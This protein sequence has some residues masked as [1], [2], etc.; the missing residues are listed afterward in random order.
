MS[1][2]LI[3]EDMCPTW[4]PQREPFHRKNVRYMLSRWR[5]QDYENYD[6]VKNPENPD[7]AENHENLD[8]V[9]NPGKILTSFSPQILIT[10]L[11]LLFF[12]WRPFINNHA[13]RFV[14]KKNSKRNPLK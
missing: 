10:C 11:G 14:K 3:C 9:E 12:Q 8:P 5:N 1:N 7:P 2:V 6:P 13:L 4:P